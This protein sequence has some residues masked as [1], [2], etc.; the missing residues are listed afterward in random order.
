MKRIAKEEM[1]KIE[2][3]CVEVEE[4][5]IWSCLD[6]SMGQAWCD[7]AEEAV[8]IIT[9]DFGF[10]RGNAK[11]AEAKALT[12]Y[13]PASHHKPYIILVPQ[14]EA[15]CT[16]IE[17]VYGKNAVRIIRYAFKKNNRFDKDKLK[18]FT[19]A[20]PA[21]Y[22]IEAINEKYYEM[23]KLEEWSRDLCDNFADWADYA[24][25]GIGFV[26]C[27]KGKPVCGAS[28]YTVYKGGIEIEIDT[29]EAF[30][31]KGL[32]TACA[33]KLILACLEK[34]LYPSWDAANLK[35]VG[36]AKKLGYEL[37]HEYVAYAVTL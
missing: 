37:S 21:D 17:E 10:L 23:S 27:Y 24:A 22:T 19:K 12:S 4:T 6:G 35:S 31:Q 30:R 13:L 16:H 5:L 18:D 33:S 3:L 9:A 34:G 20:L 14:D 36:L 2:G 1:Q 29:Q 7:E 8:K 11:S 15:W 28:S 32:A 26:V 25:R